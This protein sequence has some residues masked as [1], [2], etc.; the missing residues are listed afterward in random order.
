MNKQKIRH[1]ITEESIKIRDEIIA[2]Y[3][4]LHMYPELSLQEEKTARYIE[5]F[6]SGLNIESRRL[7]GTGIVADI[8][9]EKNGGTIALR[10]DTDALAVHEETNIEYRSR[11][12]GIMHACGHDAHTAMLLGAMKIIQGEKHLLKGT[13][14]FIFQPGEEGAGG[15][16]LMIDAGALEN[17]SSIY[18]IHVWS[19]SPSG[20]IL[21]RK[22]PLLAS[23]DRFTVILEGEGGH[24]AL[25]HFS[26]DP[27][28]VLIDIYNAFQKILSREVDPLQNALLTVPMIQGSEACNIIPSTAS[29]QGSLRTVDQ[30]SR[31]RIL[32]RMEEIVAGYSQAWRCRGSFELAPVFYPPLEN[33]AACIERISP[34]FEDAVLL[35]KPASMGSEDFSFYCEKIPGAMI[36][37]G[38]RNEEKGIIHP[39]HHPRFRVDEDILPVG[40]VIYALCGL[41]LSF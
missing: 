30:E 12:D 26:I 18:G 38:T 3:R 31:S 40:A 32:K 6:C 14:R 13:V 34:F 9:G 36:L 25:P 7:A 23:S 2:H 33:H 24:A 37:L 5:N 10:A 15:A 8:K 19:E 39:H 35:E 29:F 11:H 4:N 27:V 22:G 28:A 17:V 41:S 21:L 1:L 16:K 20:E